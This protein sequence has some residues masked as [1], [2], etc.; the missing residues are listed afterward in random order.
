MS[1]FAQ[2]IMKIIIKAA[3]LLRRYIYLSV[4]NIIYKRVRF[5]WRR[6]RDC[7]RVRTI[8]SRINIYIILWWWNVCT[9]THC[10]SNVIFCVKYNFS[11]SSSCSIFAWY[12]NKIYVVKLH[13]LVQKRGYFYKG[14]IFFL[15][16]IFIFFWF[17]HSAQQTHFHLRNTSNCQR[18]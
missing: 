9:S 8:Y 15:F 3:I 16:I 7:L 2:K 5:P 13:S 10:E 17:C 6:R 11:R 12:Y 18:N 1:V 4:Y 14:V